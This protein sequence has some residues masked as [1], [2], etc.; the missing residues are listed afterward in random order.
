MSRFVVLLIASFALALPSLG[1]SPCETVPASVECTLLDD[2]ESYPPG[3]PPFKWRTTTNDELIPLTAKNAMSE[4]HNFYVRKEGGNQFVQGFT[5]DKSIRLV[6]SRKTTLRWNVSNKPY[7]RW[8]WRAHALPK[9]ANEKN[10]DKN[11]TGGAVYVTFERNWLG[12][13]KSIK[14]TYSSALEPGTTVD[15]GNLKVLVVASKPTTGTGTWVSHERN[16][17]EDYKRLFGDKPDKTP[18]AVMLWS[19]SNTVNSTGRVDFDD[20]MLLSG[21]TLEQSAASSK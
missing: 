1:Q 11:D 9:G 15:Y 20:I 5:R 8:R 14:Y 12:L 13:P 6:L 21:P 10:D 3:D 18:L 7:L 16:V 2:F 4:A 17:V 19:D